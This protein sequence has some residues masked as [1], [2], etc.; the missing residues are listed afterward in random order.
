M[1]HVV[2]NLAWVTEISASINPM[3]P[4]S[5]STSIE[6][7]YTPQAQRQRN[8]SCTSYS[9]TKKMSFLCSDHHVKEA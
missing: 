4:K 3:R 6:I 9:G 8:G 1:A 2:Q 5:R 7:I